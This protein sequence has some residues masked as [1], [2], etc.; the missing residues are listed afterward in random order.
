M[1]NFKNQLFDSRSLTYE[2]KIPIS[3]FRRIRSESDSGHI[4]QNI[5]DTEEMLLAEISRGD[6][7]L[8]DLNLFSD[9]VDL[10]VYMPDQD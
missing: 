2:N 7:Q 6:F 5:M 1:I 10:Y 9:M 8:V 4:R 3:E